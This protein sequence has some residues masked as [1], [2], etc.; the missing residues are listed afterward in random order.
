MTRH[1]HVGERR[2]GRGLGTTLSFLMKTLRMLLLM[3]MVLSAAYIRPSM[4]E[5]ETNDLNTLGK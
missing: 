3:L 4:A 5:S 2:G 1:V